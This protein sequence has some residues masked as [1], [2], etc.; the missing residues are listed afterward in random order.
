MSMASTTVFVDTRNKRVCNHFD[1]F[2][3][4]VAFLQIVVNLVTY[5]NEVMHLEITDST[6]TL[7][8]FVGTTFL[9]ALFGG[10]IS[11]SYVDRFKMNF[12]SACTELAFCSF[13]LG[14][15]DTMSMAFTTV[16]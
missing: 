12:F 10:M 3:D 8:N 9:V 14:M 15:L 13:L 16:Y 4:S 1:Q 6:T 7:T 2:F 11:D 5:F